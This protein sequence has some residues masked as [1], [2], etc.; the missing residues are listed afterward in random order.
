MQQDYVYLTAIHQ[1]TGL[2]RE[3]KMA[4]M[5]IYAKIFG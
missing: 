2:K 3:K 4:Y 5:Q 1:Q